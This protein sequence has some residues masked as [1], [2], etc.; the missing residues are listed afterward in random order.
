MT[1]EKVI[2]SRSYPEGTLDS[3]LSRIRNIQRSFTFK[4]DCRRTPRRRKS[5]SAGSAP[6]WIINKL[7]F[8]KQ[9]GRFVC[10]FVESV[11]ENPIYFF[12]LSREVVSCVYEFVSLLPRV[13]NSF[14]KH[15]CAT[16]CRIPHAQTQRENRWIES[17][18]RYKDK[19]EIVDCQ[20][21]FFVS[22]QESHVKSGLES[23]CYRERYLASPL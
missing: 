10:F 5:T 23:K 7:L 22:K 20:S 19:N 13:L 18:E 12:F 15:T 6:S 1:W 16:I 4:A 2:A 8:R 9:A 14:G 11:K 3:P 17:F 21:F